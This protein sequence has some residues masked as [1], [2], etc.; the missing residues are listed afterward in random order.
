MKKIYLFIPVLLIALAAMAFIAPASKNSP[1]G[2]G[3]A[4]S[5]NIY[6]YTYKD[7]HTGET[8]SLAKYKGKK[9]L[10]VNTASQCGNTPQYAGLEKLYEKYKGKLVIVGFPSNDFGQQEPGPND[11]IAQ[12]C[13]LNYGVSFPMSQKIEVKGGAI[14]PIYKW[15]TTKDL[16]G[17][18]DSDVK[19]NFQKYLVDEKGNFVDMFTPKTQ[20]LADNVIAAIEK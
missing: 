12:F 10:F 6:E 9:I 7:L 2:P 13:K 1:A 15:L 3:K 8:I 16:N 5:K 17:K 14:D 4:L 18:M 20:P 19:W 11:S